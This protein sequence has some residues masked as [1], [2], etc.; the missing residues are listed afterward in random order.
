MK[1]L[2]LLA[3]VAAA[4]SLASAQ[5]YRWDFAGVFPDTA[6]TTGTPVRTIINRAH[7]NNH[8][9]AVD[10]EGKIWL[11]PYYARSGD[12]VAVAWDTKRKIA[13]A[14]Y[15]FNPNGTPATSVAPDGRVMFATFP[16]GSRDT[17]G[18][19][20]YLTATGAKAWD[21]RGPR[22]I[23][24]DG[25]G[26]IV[27]T[28]AN[29]ATSVPIVARINHKTGAGIA[30][31]NPV[32]VAGLEPRISAPA[33][34][35][36]GSVFLTSVFAGDPLVMLNPDLTLR[37]TLETADP[38][39]NRAILSNAGGD[40]LYTPYY[41]KSYLLRYVRP[42]V[43][44]EFS[45]PDTLLRGFKIES[46][47][48][49]PRPGTS[50]WLWVSAGSPNDKNTVENINDNTWYAFNSR[51]LAN[52]MPGVPLDSI[53]WS[54]A[55]TTGRPRGIAF[56]ADGQTAYLGQFSNTGEPLSVHRYVRTLANSVDDSRWVPAD[57]T[58]AS[59]A[60][61]PVRQNAR[62]RFTLHATTE[63]T[64][65]LFDLLGRE[66]AVL[67]QGTMQAGAH[68]AVLDGA[69]LAP[70]AYLLRLDADGYVLTQRVVVAR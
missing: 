32:A 47:A 50:P 38:G 17:L 3:A 1:K 36:D 70:G 15:V 52:N 13:G 34:A 48:W 45:K 51:A 66:V 54:R 4:P 11:V 69:A 24:V 10:G 35:S 59:V 56:S 5:M 26:D 7:D 61:N 57:L 64:V 63:A 21:P 53:K 9:I 62:V 18:G 55:A 20:T 42:S 33:A 25:N 44:D 2:I 16:D 19:Y 49:Q 29:A 8:G 37:S 60:P 65:R 30:K 46:L 41:D 6:E 58:L 28:F 23:A 40:T 12:S 31:A 27:V 43:F 39:F 67:S 68:E 22:G 14:I